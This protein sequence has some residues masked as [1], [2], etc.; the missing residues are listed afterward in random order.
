MKNI[1]QYY[2]ITPVKVFLSFSLPSQRS[3]VLEVIKVGNFDHYAKY[4]TSLE[5]PSWR[6]KKKK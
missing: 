2:I 4:T 1:I 6:L 5:S 3:K